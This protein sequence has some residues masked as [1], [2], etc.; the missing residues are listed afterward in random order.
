MAEYNR[1]VS[2]VYVYENNQ[3]TLNNG[4]V[5]VE[6][7]DNRCY[8][9]IHMKDLFGHPQTVFDVYMVKRTDGRLKGVLLGQMKR[10]GSQGE[11]YRETQKDNIEHSGI[12]LA[13]MAGIVVVSSQGQRYG[14]CW[15]DDLLDMRSF[16]QGEDA[17]GEEKQGD[18]QKAEGGTKPDRED[19]HKEPEFIMV[20]AEEIAAVSEALQ[21]ENKAAAGDEMLL[22]EKA[23]VRETLSSEET[24]AVSESFP[25]EETGTDAD[26][27]AGDFDGRVSMSEAAVAAAPL[28][29]Q[30]VNR[31]L[32]LEEKLEKMITQGMKMYPFE[33]DDVVKCVRLEL[34]DIGM[35]PMKFWSYVSNSFLLHS[36]YSYRHLIL[37]K[38][39]DGSYFLGVPGMGQNKDR[40]MAQ[41]FGFSKFKPIR[42]N[43]KGQSDFG[44]WYIILK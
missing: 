15:D 34:Q 11:F 42:D 23:A 21:A 16:T 4:F 44:Y 9:Y 43:E 3:K 17:S 29:G 24:A 20:P 1:F 25:A 18:S 28:I 33:D 19:D 30:P 7:K 5:R 27:D 2:Y 41:L 35:M 6:T 36:Y 13:E 8:V 31:K 14:T 12:S 10:D 22:E 40:F 38:F 39:G 32:T 37:G 26:V